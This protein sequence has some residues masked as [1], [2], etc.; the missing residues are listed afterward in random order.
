MEHLPWATS[1][2]EEG[3][4]VPLEYVSDLLPVLPAVGPAVIIIVIVIRRV[5]RVRVTVAR[6][7][8]LAIEFGD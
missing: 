7:F 5:R 2:V 4:L 6:W 3:A 8:G 1:L